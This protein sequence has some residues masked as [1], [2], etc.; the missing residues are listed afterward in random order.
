MKADCQAMDSSV[1]SG[2]VVTLPRIN[3][4]G[5][6]IDNQQQIERD[7]NEPT[8]T[9]DSLNKREMLPRSLLS[10]LQQD[11]LR[12]DSDATLVSRDV[13]DKQAA[14]PHV[15]EVQEPQLNRSSAI[16]VEKTLKNEEVNRAANGNSMQDSK[17]VEWRLT[18]HQ[19]GETSAA[20]LLMEV[21]SI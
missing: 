17:V 21:K 2:A 14:G 6:V 4:N 9:S 1:G 7:G 20:I 18:L 11:D 8:F 12:R 3:D 5:T 13:E 15:G 10:L 19:I 16:Q